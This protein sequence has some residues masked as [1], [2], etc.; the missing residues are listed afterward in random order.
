MGKRGA[1]WGLLLCLLL[2]GCAP[3]SAR[4][5]IFAMD[6]VMDLTVYGA[7]A[8]EGVAA[9]EVRLNGLEAALSVTRQDS[10]VW[11]VNH[12]GE[13]GEAVTPADE[14]VQALLSAAVALGE[15]TGGALDATLY[16]VARLWGFTTGEYRVPGEEELAAALGRTG[17]EKL[18]AHGDAFAV[19]A[20]VE[21]DFGALAKGYAGEVCRQMLLEAGA[22]SALLVL[23]GNVQTVGAKPDGSPWRVEVQDPAGESGESLGV[24][25]VTDRAVVTSGSYQRYFE[26]D[27]VRYGHILDPQTGRPVEGDLLSVT[28]VGASG[29]LC[30]GLS[31]ALFVL[32]REGALDFWRAHRDWDFELLLVD[33]DGGATI[34]AGLAEGFSL[35]AQAGYTLY[36]EAGE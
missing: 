7:G 33:K 2:A 17:Y 6:T 9:V 13:S 10:E 8:E 35:K 14:D 25:T 1:A 34:T 23:G 28:V 27:G 3:K 15:A 20:G 11:A 12:P 18:Q 26:E 21:L 19:P 24:L 30:D 32:G 29:T 4:R 16:P 36:V 31:T 22:T 5:T